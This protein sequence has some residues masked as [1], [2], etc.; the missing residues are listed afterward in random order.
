MPIRMEGESREQ[1]AIRVREYLFATNTT[2]GS[3]YY[4]QGF[5]EAYNPVSPTTVP[6][7]SPTVAPKLDRGA[8]S[9]ATALLLDQYNTHTPRPHA[10]RRER[11]YISSIQYEARRKQTAREILY[12]EKPVF[13]GHLDYDRLVEIATICKDIKFDKNHWVITCAKSGQEVPTDYAFFCSGRAYAATDVPTIEVCVACDHTKSD[14]TLINDHEG[15]SIYVCNRCL[16]STGIRCGDCSSRLK[17]QWYHEGLC[18]TCYE[19]IVTDRPYRRFAYTKKWC[20]DKLGKIIKSTRLFSFEIEAAIDNPSYVHLLGSSL[21]QEAGMSGDS[22]IRGTN[23]GVEVQSPRLQGQMGEDFT[24]RVTAVFKASKATVNESCGMH[25]HLDGVGILPQSRSQPPNALK[26][27]WKAHL[28]FEDVLFSFL[29]FNRRTNRYCRPLRDYFKVSEIELIETVFDAE[30]L[31]YKQQDY[32]SI[33]SEKQHHH[34]ASRYFGVNF[35]SLFSGGHLE[36]RHHSGT[37]NA[38]KILQ[39]ANLHA[40]IMDAAVNREFSAD[41]LSE[42]QATTSLKDKTQML[43]D[44]IHLAPASQAFFLQR[45]AKFSDK[46][47]IEDGLTPLP[48]NVFAVT[49]TNSHPGWVL[50]TI[51]TDELSDNQTNF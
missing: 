34:H 11:D 32:D 40:L 50:D 47:Q 29:P 42:A 25:V 46:G 12:S 5:G 19:H 22:S 39:W 23:F 14:C 31:W 1:Y 8:L 7:D 28:I 2:N 16:N 17:P 48:Q 15:G 41:F 20:S 38:K 3:P 45:Q 26:D 43:F 10:E 13:I 44:R 51:S 37:I 35:H 21:P 6:T 49:G 4:F 36:L 24:T 33:R 9:K 18:Q 30:K 27:L